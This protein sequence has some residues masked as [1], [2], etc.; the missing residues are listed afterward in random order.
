[1]ADTSQVNAVAG[2]VIFVDQNGD[3]VI[4]NEDKVVI[5]NRTPTSRTASQPERSTRTST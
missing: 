5:G 1:M 4:N 3:G 2:D